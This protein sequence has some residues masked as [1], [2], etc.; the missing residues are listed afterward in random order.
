MASGSADSQES[1]QTISY[2]SQ[3]SESA[4]SH[5]VINSQ[6]GSDVSEVSTLSYDAA[7]TVAEY[8]AAEVTE[9]VA[10]SL[11]PDSF[12]SENAELMV[13]D[14]SEHAELRDDPVTVTEIADDTLASELDATAVELQVAGPLLPMCTCP[15]ASV[16]QP[17][18]RPP[19]QME[20]VVNHT[21][22]VYHHNCP[23]CN[24]RGAVNHGVDSDSDDSRE[25]M[26]DDDDDDDDDNDNHVDKLAAE[27]QDAYALG[28]Q[29][30]IMADILMLWP[31]LAQQ[32]GVSDSVVNSPAEVAQPIIENA[33]NAHADGNDPRFASI[34][35]GYYNYGNLDPDSD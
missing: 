18:P 2:D 7:E 19:Q 3:P 11:V 17:L 22:H 35:W 30:A 15:V 5:P 16:E 28:Q 25:C 13:T 31:A 24:Y 8:H 34:R 32:A 1:G 23:M 29:Y 4:Y 10:T 12:V 21:R 26:D 20:I 9:I 14:T 33:E 6:A 27:R